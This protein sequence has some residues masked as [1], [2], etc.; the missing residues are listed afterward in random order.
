MP[1][2]SAAALAANVELARLTRANEIAALIEQF[3]PDSKIVRIALNT[4]S[5]RFAEI[6]AER[7]RE[8]R[9][10]GFSDVGAGASAES[11]LASSIPWFEGLQ[12]R[13]KKPARELYI[14]AEKRAAANLQKLHALLK[15]P[16]R[17]LIKIFEL[18]RTGGAETLKQRAELTI[19]RLWREKPRKLNLPSEIGPGEAARRIIELHRMRRLMHSRNGETM[20]F[21]GMAFPRRLMAGKNRLVRRAG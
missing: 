11:V 1:R 16:V 3:E 8:G 18:N 12:A 15:P 9:F 5:G 13:A 19:S 4:G 14:V 7:R 17:N 6:I 2:V 20:R 21:K 10:A